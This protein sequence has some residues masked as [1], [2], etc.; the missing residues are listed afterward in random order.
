MFALRHTSNIRSDKTQT[1]VSKRRGRRVRSALPLL[2]VL[3]AFLLAACG[4]TAATATVTDNGGGAAATAV[5]TDNGGGGAGA[6]ANVAGNGA[7]QIAEDAAPNFQ[8]TLFETENHAKG[9]LLTLIDLAGKPVVLNFWFPSC[10]PCRAELP[11]FEA[12]FQAHKDE[13]AFI[14][15]QQLGLDSIQEGQDFIN[16]IGVTYAVG[17]DEANIVPDYKI[18]GFP[19]TVFLNRDLSI[20]KK[21]TGAL[22]GEKLEEL[23]QELLQ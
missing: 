20:E 19:T 12:S 10:P 8:L 9:E 21:W 5:V 18:I 4:G 11:D 2:A 16:E 17:P 13:V 23:I 3:G 6:S 14:G 1:A 22:N 15:L 7:V